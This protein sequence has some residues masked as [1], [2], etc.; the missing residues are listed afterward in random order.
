MAPESNHAP[1]LKDHEINYQVNLPRIHVSNMSWKAE[2]HIR[3][4]SVLRHD[5][6]C[7]LFSFVNEQLNIHLK[8]NVNYL[9]S[10]NIHLKYNVN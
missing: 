1:A 5:M 3:Y 6:L 4:A 9:V 2:W 7:Q 10:P 8:Y